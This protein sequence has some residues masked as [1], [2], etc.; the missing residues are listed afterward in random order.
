MSSRAR[1]DRDNAMIIARFVGLKM[2]AEG[3]AQGYAEG[4]AQS[5]AE[6]LAQGRA[7]MNAKVSQ[8][9][10]AHPEFRDLLETLLIRDEQPSTG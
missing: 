9:M 7:E 8:L 2:K 1:T 10:E 3:F 4:Y 6:G 5:Y